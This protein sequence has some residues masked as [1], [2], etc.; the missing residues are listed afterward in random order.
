MQ[1]NYLNCELAVTLNVICNLCMCV[2]LS[3][4]EVLLKVTGA[5]IV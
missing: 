5:Q 1:E 2:F 4:C 3:Y